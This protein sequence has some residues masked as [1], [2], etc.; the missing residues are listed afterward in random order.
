MEFHK[1]KARLF[2]SMMY[3]AFEIQN[4]MPLSVTIFHNFDRSVLSQYGPIKLQWVQHDFVLDYQKVETF[5][6][7]KIV[8][9]EKVRFYDQALNSL[10]LME[11]KQMRKH[12]DRQ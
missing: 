3:Y 11:V 5:G 1:F 6:S 10:K 9:A 8:E 4:D 12:K 2:Y 7:C